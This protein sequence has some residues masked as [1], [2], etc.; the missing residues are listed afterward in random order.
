MTRADIRTLVY[1]WLDDDAGGYFTS[2]QVNT[3]INNAH[4]QVQMLLLQAG[5]NYY[6]QP[7][8]TTTVAGQADYVLPAD[9]MVEHRLEL[10]QSG[11][12]YNENRLPI[13]PITTNQQDKV[14]I[15]LGMPSCYYIKKDRFTL[16]PTPDNVYV[17]RLYYSPMVTDLASDSDVP[18]VPE[19]YM[20]YVALLA[21]YNGFIKDDRVPSTLQAKMVQFETLLKQMSEDRTQDQSRSVVQV[22]DYDDYGGIG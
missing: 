13:Y 5:E 21:A 18:D 8:Q 11:T 22:T 17:L 10:V 14:Q 6:M 2:A 12:S 15:S 4:R 9:F 7:V 16:S 20:E 19:Q 3:W 1:S